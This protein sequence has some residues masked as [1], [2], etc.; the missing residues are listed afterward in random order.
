MF[1]LVSRCTWGH[2]G[3]PHRG[4]KGYPRGPRLPFFLLPPH[5]P[6]QIRDHFPEI[7]GQGIREGAGREER[8]EEGDVGERNR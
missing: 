4:A 7:E 1:H 8:E 5:L 3:S 2:E 6:T